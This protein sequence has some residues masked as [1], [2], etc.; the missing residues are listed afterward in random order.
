MT[1][2]LEEP[3]VDLAAEEEEGLADDLVVGAPL[4]PGLRPGG[5]ALLKMAE[6][7]RELHEQAVAATK[8]MQ[9]RAQ[10]GPPTC[11]PFAWPR[12][13]HQAEQVARVHRRKG[14]SSCTQRCRR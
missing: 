9:S 10:V 8:Q 4:P 5:W 2:E 13:S 1:D 7:R 11:E 3:W 12:S 14:R 6:T